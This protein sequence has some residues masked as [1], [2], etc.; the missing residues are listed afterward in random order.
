M[1][2]ESLRESLD[3]KL[4]LRSHLQE[5]RGR[6]LKCVIVLAAAT[7]ASFFFAKYIFYILESMAEGIDLIFIEMTEM[8]STYFHISFTCG[9]ALALPFFIYQLVMFL[10][11]ALSPTE[12]KY[13]NFLL[14]G[15]LLAFA[16]G[17]VF[18]Y[19]VLVPPA[20]KF[21]INFGS[22]I[23]TPQIRVG[24]YVSLMVKLLFAIGLCFE[25]PLLIFLL[26]KFHIVTPEKL[27][28]YRKFAMLGAFILAAIITPTFDPINQTIVAVPL[29][30][31]YEIGILLAKLARRREKKVVPTESY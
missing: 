28:K 21:L 11:P 19:F 7:A 17:L 14:P 23:A 3:T 4:P 16:A 30:V 20:A 13:L 29:I 26:S 12:R 18:G 31:L 24:N 15:V 25:T 1:L 22:D 2:R 6:L 10:R 27:A 5:L 9:F 8:I